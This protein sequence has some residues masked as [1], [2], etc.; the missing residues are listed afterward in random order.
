MSFVG[1]NDWGGQGT[2]II[3]EAVAGEAAQTLSEV[4]KL[5]KG[6]SVNTFD[7]AEKL[8]KVKKN[9]YYAPKF[10]TY[11]EYLKTLDIKL[12]KGYYLTK[13][14]ELMEAASIPRSVYEPVGIAKLRLVSRID[15]EQQDGQP[16]MYDLG[17]G[18]P[19][20]GVEI[21]KAIMA[22]AETQD[23][24]ELEQ[25]VRKV[26][27]QVGDNAPT[28]VNIGMTEGQRAKWEEAVSLAKAN[29]GSVSKDADGNYQDASE[30]RCAEVIAVNYILD[31]NNYPEGE[32]PN[33][34]EKDLPVCT[35]EPPVI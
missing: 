14:V 20:Q 22:H 4:K 15:L 9:K 1:G 19:V 34:T 7:L 32:G 25:F 24:D 21:V 23:P 29:I 6:L 10:N 28:W 5:V 3:G 26:N 17:T 31:P 13:I 16:K 18:L 35:K 8:H 33:E 30:G 12:S 27:G 11:G 2:T